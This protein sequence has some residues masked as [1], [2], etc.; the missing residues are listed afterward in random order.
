MQVT[1]CGSDVCDTHIVNMVRKVSKKDF[2]EPGDTK[3]PW[4][5]KPQLTSSVLGLPVV[6]HYR[7]PVPTTDTQLA[8]LFHTSAS[9]EKLSF[10]GEFL[11]ATKFCES[12]MTEVDLI[13]NW[14]YAYPS[15]IHWFTSSHGFISVG[16]GKPD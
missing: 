15:K 12:E 13:L 5:G 1:E 4:K 8:I 3:W 11:S 7:P 2:L 14:S 10:G 6:V 9:E 16:F